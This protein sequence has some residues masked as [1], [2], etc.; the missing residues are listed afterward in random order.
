MLAIFFSLLNTSTIRISKYKNMLDTF[1]SLKYMY[2]YLSRSCEYFSAFTFCH[3]SSLCAWP[4]KNSPSSKV[5]LGL[6]S[7]VHSTTGWLAVITIRR[8]HHQRI[9]WV[10][11]T[12]RIYEHDLKANT[13]DSLQLRLV[14]GAKWG[15]KS[16]QG[17]LRNETFISCLCGRVMPKTN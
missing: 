12:C 13:A 11:P 17:W 8:N 10:C 7:V 16:S 9:K 1:T 2:L 6:R 3:M 5:M 15:A 4:A 14:L